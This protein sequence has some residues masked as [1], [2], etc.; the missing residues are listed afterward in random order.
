M[1]PTR[2]Q[3]IADHKEGNTIEKVHG[4]ASTWV[5]AAVYGANDGI[6]T[7]FAVVAGVAGAGLPGH[8]VVILGIANMVA[9][10]LSM[11]LGDFLGNLSEHTYKKRQLTL[12]RWEWEQIPEIENREIVEHFRS[13]G[14]SAADAK[15]IANI[16]AKNKEYISKFSFQ[17]ELGE[18]PDDQAAQWHTGLVTFLAFVAAGSLPLLPYVFVTIGLPVPVESQFA[19]SIIS[20]VIALFAVGAARTLLVRGSWIL[21]GLQMLGIGSIAAIAAYVL[22]V[23]IERGL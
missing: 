11:G 20:T 21:N 1:L 8:V 23:I 10:G 15:E 5:K 14:Y 9:D 16:M 6:V 19:I 3:L 13:E 18:L 4:F 17:Q 12:E 22:G 2:D 7:T